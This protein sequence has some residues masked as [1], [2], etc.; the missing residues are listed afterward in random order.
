M[1]LAATQCLDPSRSVIRA[2][3]APAMPATPDEFNEFVAAVR[4][5]VDTR[6]GAWLDARVALAEGRGAPV[7]AVARALRQLAMRGGKRM[8]PVLLAAA[9]VACGGEGGVAPVAMAG[10]SLELLQVY[11]LVHDDWMDGDAV[12]RGGP[13]V[14][15]LMRG[16]FEGPRADA[17]SVLAGDLAAAWARAALVEV[18]LPAARVAGAAAELARAEEDVVQGQLLDVVGAASNLPDVERVH[19]LKTASYSTT[20]PVRIGARLAGASDATVA[21]L[22][23]YAEPLGVAFQLRDDVLGTFGDE[24]EMGKPAGGDLRAGKRTALVVEAARDARAREALSRVL[25]R[26]DA[27]DADVRRALECLHESGARERVEA[28][29]GALAGQ[30]RAALGEM[31]LTTAGRSVLEGA[32]AALTERKA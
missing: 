7:G 32:V 8:R 20:G 1:A 19:S 28:R 21:G 23:A 11:L 29:I 15:A 16:L 25:A 18:D 31:V 3:D 5:V 27:S 22:A 9:Y 10:V 17:A 24:R 26:P 14:P 6:L 12:R 2:A 13:S 30:A 4:S